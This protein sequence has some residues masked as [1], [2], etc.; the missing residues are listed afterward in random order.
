MFLAKGKM[1]STK[2]GRQKSSTVQDPLVYLLRRS[3]GIVLAVLLAAFPVARVLVSATGEPVRARHAMVV[4][5]EDHATRVGLRILKDGG[6]A[7]DAAIAVGFALA[8]TYPR[9]GNLGGGG[10]ML[11]RLRDGGS[12]FFDFR[13]RAPSAPTPGYREKNRAAPPPTGPA[14]IDDGSGAIRW[15]GGRPS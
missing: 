3:P 6:N 15:P 10:F 12:T 1:F 14:S 9:A 5:D 4:T 8:V 11:V 7:V 13:E 2:R